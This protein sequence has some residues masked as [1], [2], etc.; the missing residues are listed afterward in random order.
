MYD[1]DG[2]ENTTYDQITADGGI[3]F[4]LDIDFSM[5]IDNFQLKQLEFTNTATEE[6][7]ISASTEIAAA[8]LD[9]KV[10]IAK[11]EFAP[12]TIMVGWLPVIIVPVATVNVGLDGSVSVGITTDVTQTASLTTGLSYSSGAWSP[13]ST[14]SNEFSYNPPSLSAS[15][16]VKA[17]GGPQLD[18]MIYGVAGPYANIYDYLKLEADISKNPWWKLYGGLE[19]NVGV[20]VE[21]LD[22]TLADYSATVIDYSVVLAQ[23]NGPITDTTAPSV[24]TGLTAT[25]VSTSQINLSW[26]AST[27]DVG[28]A[29]YKVY[30]N[31]TYLKTATTTSA[32]DTG[33]SPST[34]YCY[35]VSAYDAAWNESGQSSQACATTLSSG[36]AISGKVTT[37]IGAGL[38]GVTITLTGTGSTTT[39]TD[40][41]GNYTFSGAQNGSYTIIPSLSGYTFSPPSISVTV[42]N[43]DVPNQNFVGSA[44]T[45]TL[46]SI[47]VTPANPSITEG[48]T[49]QF[50]AT[51]T[52]SDSTTQNL[53]TSVTWS[54]SNASVATIN[55]S[56]LAT[57]IAAGS[58][59]IK[60]TSGSISGST[61]LTVTQA[62][63]GTIQLPKT[64]QTTSYATG[65]D[66]DLEV[67]VEWPDPRFTDNGDQTITDNLTGLIWT[68]DA[69][70]PTTYTGTTLACTGG[71]KT[72]QGAL[73]YV[74]CLNSNN[75]LGYNDWRLPNRSELRSLVDYSQHGPALPS[76]YPFANIRYGGGCI[77]LVINYI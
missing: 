8:T 57:G 67:G 21:I 46:V 76:G 59:T 1:A 37:T 9:E 66:G 74:T 63:T 73:D 70:T 10:E 18:L 36:Y 22:H 27:D 54:S 58:T 12:I 53:T 61:S 3:S 72:W 39:T 14:F 33:L 24:P 5:E 71:L 38:S 49:R 40:S 75:Y 2:D 65:D 7:A 6:V 47:T 50:T 51:G 20:K 64:G 55:N 42:N 15:A 35:S 43:A 19:S 34:N 25:A 4:N 52:Y 62:A 68:K 32:S 26:T 48:A 11:L 16:E 17:Y 30:R 41:N 45:A 23:A 29:G 31:G 44:T 13:I 77:L 69:G 60:A 28:V 56:G